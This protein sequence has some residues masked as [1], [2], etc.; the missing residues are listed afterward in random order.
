MGFVFWVNGAGPNL[1]QRANL[2]IEAEDVGTIM[3][4]DGSDHLPQSVAVDAAGKHVYFTD[5]TSS[6]HSIG[7]CG[8]DGNNVDT[9]RSLG[10]RVPHGIAVHPTETMSTLCARSARVCRMAL[11]C[12]RPKK[13]FTGLKL[14]SPLCS[15]AS[16][17]TCT[18]RRRCRRQRRATHLL[19]L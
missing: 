1:L 17:T 19:C 4:R 9:V 10:T 5:Q 11:L 13:R 7:R 6:E 3:P 14:S 15:W 16:W 8:Y 2:G 12:I 18:K